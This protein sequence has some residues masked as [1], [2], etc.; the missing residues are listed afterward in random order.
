MLYSGFYIENIVKRTITQSYAR[1][2]ES[3]RHKK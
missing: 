3:L 2:R 1:T